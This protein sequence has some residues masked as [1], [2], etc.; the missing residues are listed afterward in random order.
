MSL[1]I[2]SEKIGTIDEVVNKH[3]DGRY[4]QGEYD[5]YK[6]I[7]KDC[8]ASSYNWHMWYDLSLNIPAGTKSDIQID[9]L[10]I[11]EKGAIVVEVKGGNIEIQSG[12]YFYNVK[13]NLTQLDMNPFKQ[14]EEYKYSLIN[15]K[16]INS[17]KLFVENVVA[18]P[19]SNL[20]KTNLHTQ[21]DLGY[22]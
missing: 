6:R 1:Q 14:S 15:N 20:S 18:F 3:K 9:F 19:H 10:L 8:E 21:L 12:H 13:G 7:C 5:M 22:R 4:Y 11:C 17:D 2:H 16:V